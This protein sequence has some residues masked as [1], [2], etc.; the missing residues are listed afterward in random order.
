[1]WVP[2]VVYV[3]FMNRDFHCYVRSIDRL[4]V[5]GE[6]WP[7]PRP[8][9]LSTQ[10]CT[11]FVSWAEETAE[12]AFAAVRREA[13]RHFARG[14]VEFDVE[15]VHR[16]CIACDNG[17]LRDKLGRKMRKPCACVALGGPVESRFACTFKPALSP[18]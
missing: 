1:M 3:L 16:R 7:A 2:G 11:G 5:P 10:W 8:F 18:A 13:E 14:A 15:I 17:V 12:E 9:P 4:P 6:K